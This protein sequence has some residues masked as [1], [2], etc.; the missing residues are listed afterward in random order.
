MELAE[1]ALVLIIG[2]VIGIVVVYKVVQSQLKKGLASQYQT[3]YRGELE[4]WKA[5]YELQRHDEI[6]K[7][8][9]TEKNKALNGSRSTLKGRINEQLTTLY[10]DFTSRF[11]AADARFIGTPIDFI[12]FKNL[13]KISDKEQEPIEVVFLEVKA[14]NPTLSHTQRAVRDAIEN[15]RVKFETMKITIAEKPVG[16]SISN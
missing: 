10:P 6:E 15:H 7:Q 11:M 13:S 8:I 1:A 9:E 14:G 2:L 5:Q 3:Q 4:T 16:N 12:I